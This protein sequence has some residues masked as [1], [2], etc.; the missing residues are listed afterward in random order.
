[1]VDCLIAVCVGDLPLAHDLFFSLLS[2]TFFLLEQP[3][4]DNPLSERRSARS[5]LGRTPGDAPGLQSVRPSN[6]PR[7]AILFSWVQSELVV[8][9]DLTMPQ[10]GRRASR[11]G[12]AHPD[13]LERTPRYRVRPERSGAMAW[14]TFIAAPA[15]RKQ[16][17]TGLPDLQTDLLS[18]DTCRVGTICPRRNPLSRKQE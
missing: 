3:V 16:R 17:A 9:R 7:D 15:H 12:L 1:M 4:F 14:I 18:R 13:A 6:H 2:C 11:P 10:I 5:R 8:P